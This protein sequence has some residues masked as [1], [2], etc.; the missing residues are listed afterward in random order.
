MN[1]ETQKKQLILVFVGMYPQSYK[2][3]TNYFSPYCN[4]QI[5]T[6]HRGA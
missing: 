2:Y 1:V 5:H 6:P 4:N 3:L